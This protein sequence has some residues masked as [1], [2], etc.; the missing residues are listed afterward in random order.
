MSKVEF[1]SSFSKEAV[2]R[3]G[4]IAAEIADIDAM[5]AFDT[6]ALSS[7][8]LICA[9]E[10]VHSDFKKLLYIKEMIFK[11]DKKGQELIGQDVF[12]CLYLAAMNVLHCHDI[13][14]RVEGAREA[15]NLIEGVVM[16]YVKEVRAKI[17]EEF[18]ERYRFRH[19]G[20]G[21]EDGY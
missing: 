21:E 16:R 19:S 13:D 17:F 14:G 7:E 3:N 12:D 18:G 8:E 4:K 15:K 5:S 20:G 6:I 9:L 11:N 1:F 2:E 10:Y